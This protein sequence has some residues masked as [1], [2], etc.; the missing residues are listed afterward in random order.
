MALLSGHARSDLCLLR[1]NGEFPVAEVAALRQ[2]LATVTEQLSQV[3]ERQLRLAALE[4][5]I[6]SFARDRDVLQSNVRDFTVRE[7]ESRSAEA[8]AE[9]GADNIRIVGRATAPIQGSSPKKIV[10]ILA[11]LF[12]GFTALCA[13][14]V[15]M[16]LRPDLVTASSAGRTLDLP[17]LGAARV[18]R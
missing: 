14:L 16:F 10:A 8:I 11:L 13:G 12:A 17:V 4:P 1:G 7:Q 9:S 18:K 15:H 6:S 2:S 3:T 5:Q